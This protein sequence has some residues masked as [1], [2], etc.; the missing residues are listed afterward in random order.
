MIAEPSTVVQ[1]A[2]RRIFPARGPWRS[3][4]ALALIWVVI[5]G[6]IVLGSV[7]L[8]LNLR[9]RDLASATD[10][11]ATDALMLSAH[12]ENSFKILEAVQAG[13]LE[14][15]HGEGISTENQYVSV[16]SGLPMHRTL[17]ARV[18]AIPYVGGITMIERRGILV[19]S[20]YYWPMPFRDLSDREY[21]HTL[22]ASELNQRYVT[23]PLQNRANGQWTVYV[24]RRVEGNNGIFLGVLLGEINFTHFQRF[25]AEVAPQPDAV[26]SMSDLQGM[27]LVRHPSAA[28]VIGTAPQTGAFQLLQNGSDHGT[29]RNVSPIDGM[30]R[31]VA[32][33]R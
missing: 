28:G 17:L 7:L 23:K 30:D 21:F 4:P 33:H 18:A 12:L 6:A 2:P 32:V 22:S 31:L 5:A 26:V 8:T 29:T 14:Q 9:E 13:I 1:P 11:L 24:A 27:M 20:T 10:N 25:F 19:N 3:M 16:A 15:L